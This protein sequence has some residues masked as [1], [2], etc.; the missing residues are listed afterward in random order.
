M[1]QPLTGVYVT[2]CYK[3]LTVSAQLLARKASSLIEK[4]IPAL[5]NLSK[6]K[7]RISNHEY[8]MSKDGILSNLKK[9]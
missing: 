6:S 2:A 4:E 5:R 7:Y 9:D 8:R 1:L 3:N